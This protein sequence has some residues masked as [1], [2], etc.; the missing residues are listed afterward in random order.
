M[1]E[2]SESQDVSH[3]HTDE[4]VNQSSSLNAS[5][6]TR[7]R[8]IYPANRGVLVVRDWVKYSLLGPLGSLHINLRF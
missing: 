5:S 6:P 3:N 2:S 8:S 7:A 1:P 4:V